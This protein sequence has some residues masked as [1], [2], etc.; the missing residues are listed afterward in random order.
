MLLLQDPE[1]QMH[2]R[3]YFKVNIKYFNPLAY[4]SLILIANT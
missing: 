3:A 1:A 4:K 2:I